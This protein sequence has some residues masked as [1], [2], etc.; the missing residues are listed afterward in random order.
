MEIKAEI[1]A[2]V[3]REISDTEVARRNARTARLRQ[4]RLE[5]EAE[6]KRV[7]IFQDRSLRF[8]FLFLRMSLSRNRFPPSVD[9]LSFIK[10]SGVWALGHG[11]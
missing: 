11:S 4:A 6:L 5:K 2:R 8:R 1:S 9:M 7:A 3:A 10:T